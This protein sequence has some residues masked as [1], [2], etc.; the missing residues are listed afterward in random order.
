[1]KQEDSNKIQMVELKKESEFLIYNTEKQLKENDT[2]IPQDV[3]DRIRADINS[4]N[5]AIASNNLDNLKNAMEKLR[6]SAMEMGRAIYAQHSSTGQQG[7]GD[8]QGQQ[9]QQGTGDQQ[10]QGQN[11][12]QQGQNQGQNQGNQGGQSGQGGQEN[13]P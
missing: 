9:G 11:Q 5:E 1:M 3:K 2:K 10:N 13:K 12:G 7:T 6:N 4:V 8:Q